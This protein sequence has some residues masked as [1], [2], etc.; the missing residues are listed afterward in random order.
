MGQDEL[1]DTDDF[2]LVESR[3]KRRERRKSI[4]VAS[5]GKGKKQD[6]ENPGL[7]KVRGRKPRVA[8]SKKKPKS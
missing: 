2:I 8:P 5:V 1:S 7:Q 6:Q 4:Q 3:K